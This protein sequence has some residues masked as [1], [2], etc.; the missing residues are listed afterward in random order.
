MYLENY[1]HDSVLW[2]LI[3]K[4]KYDLRYITKE[5]GNCQS[6]KKFR[7]KAQLKRKRKNTYSRQTLILNTIDVLISPPKFVNK[8]EQTH[9][10]YHTKSMFFSP[11]MV[12]PTCHIKIFRLYSLGITIL[13][14][15]TTGG[16]NT[17][18]ALHNYCYENFFHYKMWQKTHTRELCCYMHMLLAYNTH[19]SIN[20]KIY[21][22]FIM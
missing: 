15:L 17:I 6:K 12:G 11:K 5:N 1:Y 3:L 22:N 19:C 4:T 8:T 10:R 7:T 20:F 9:M 13:L 2:H 14:I 16:S 18:K 21:C